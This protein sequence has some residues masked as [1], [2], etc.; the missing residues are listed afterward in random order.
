MK[1]NVSFF[2][3]RVKGILR[4]G[5]ADFSEYLAHCDERRAFI[6]GF[7]GSA[8]AFVQLFLSSDRRAYFQLGCAIVTL[9]KAYLFT[10]GRYFLQA[11]NQL[12]QLV[13]ISF[14]FIYFTNG[15]DFATGIG[16]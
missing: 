9:D 12:D 6:S 10:D 8:G 4:C 13:H 7:N 15:L 5:Y 1:I 3:S 2:P 16:H 11:A 14:L